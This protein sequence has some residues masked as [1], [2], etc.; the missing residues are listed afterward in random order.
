MT[1]FPGHCLVASVLSV[2]NVFNVRLLH[3]YSTTPLV[4]LSSMG[5][6]RG[7]ARQTFYVLC[8]STTY[9]AIRRERKARDR[10]AVEC[11]A[12]GLPII[13]CASNA[14][15]NSLILG[16]PSNP[17]LLL[18]PSPVLPAECAVEGGRASTLWRSPH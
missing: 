6:N 5:P 15:N 4:Q 12:R 18:F 11:T 1:S 9:M 3:H 13:H 2:F 8:G 14:S 10:K 7:N 17:T 16:L